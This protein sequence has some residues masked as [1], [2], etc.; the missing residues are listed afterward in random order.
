M[1]VVEIDRSDGR[2]EPALGAEEKLE[3]KKSNVELHFAEE[4][5]GKGTLYITTQ[6][7]IWFGTDDTKLGFSF[8]YPVL[9]MHAISRDTTQFSKSCI[10]CQLNEE[11]LS[12]IRFVPSSSADL[13]PIYEALSKCAA[14]NPDVIEHE[15]DLGDFY[16]DEG[17]VRG[18]LSQAV[19]SMAL[20]DTPSNQ[21][22]MSGLQ[23]MHYL[24]GSPGNANQ[25]FQDAE[26][27]TETKEDAEAEAQDDDEAEAEGEGDDSEMNGSSSNNSANSNSNSNTALNAPLTGPGRGKRKAGEQDGN[28]SN[29]KK[30]K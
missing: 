21:Q 27:E 7:V 20:N 23:A 9:L 6:N 24:N 10:Y 25:Q 18:N 11:E 28:S 22:Q 26:A 5:K 1:P 15:E 2:N 16:F 29:L 30:P 13:E 17:E 8:D 3:L 19:Q 14:M 12:E 4:S